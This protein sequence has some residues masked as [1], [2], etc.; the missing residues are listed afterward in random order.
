[1]ALGTDG[2]SSNN[3]TDLFA[4]MKLAAIL[5][6]GSTATRWPFCPHRPC[7][8]PPPTAPPLWAARQGRIE[9]GL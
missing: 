9:D 4:E 1:M 5:Q 2:V 3:C 8:W 6:N 7:A